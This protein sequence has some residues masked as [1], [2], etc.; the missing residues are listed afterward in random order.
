MM[1]SEI[2]IGPIVSFLWVILTA[3]V[4]S[5]LFRKIRLPPLLGAIIAGLLIG[6]SGLNIIN[7]ST[8]ITNQ[9]ILFLGSLGGLVLVFLVG[10]ESSIGE[11][12]SLS[13]QALFIGLSGMITSMVLGYVVCAIMGI[14]DLESI[15]LSIAISISSSIPSLT[16]I[17]SLGKGATK[18]ARLFSV[19]SLVDD[20]FGLILLFLI[21]TSFGKTGFNLVNLLVFIGLIA[22]FW[23][24]SLTLI[25]KLSK[26]AYDNFDYPSE[27]TTAL[28][29][30]IF[31]IIAAIASEEFLYEASFGVFLI[32]L[33]FS[34]LHPLYKYE[35]KKIFLS[36]GDI[37]L[38]P[39]FFVMIGINADLHAILGEYWLIFLTGLVTVAI[40]GK[41]LGA[42]MAKGIAK[43]ETKNAAA[44]G[45]ALVPRGGISLVIA[46][47][48]ISQGI[49]T[50]QAFSVIVTLVIITTLLAPLTTNLGFSKIED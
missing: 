43:L 46:S 36:L 30:L 3:L 38:F 10:L 6:P 2:L 13:K 7:F 47:L 22:L 34:T 39:S 48:G 20:I 44:I 24:I 9:W 27:Q 4:F 23:I 18:T 29:T 33:A 32:G 28:L 1:Y 19:S 16:A 49:L 17:M 12:K 40:I 8:P 5:W 37:L 45:L 42:L 31:I 26:W 14:P 15:I 21:V 50:G 41:V 25:P 11:I 35:I